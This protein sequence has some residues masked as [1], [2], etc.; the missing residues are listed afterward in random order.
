MIVFYTIIFPGILFTVF[1]GLII[2]W[3][4]RKLSALFQHRV[5]PPWYQNFLDV[6]KLFGKE[7][8]VPELSASVVYILA[9]I[10][11]F[12]VITALST[13]LGCAVFLGIRIAG[14]VILII[15]LL[16]LCSMATFLGAAAS[17]N[18]Y[19]GIGASRELKMLLADEL[20]LIMV[21][22]V[23]VVKSGFDFNLLRLIYGSPAITSISGVI[24]YIL[25]LVCIQA[26]LAI[27]PF[28][29]PEAETELAGGVEIE[30]SGVLLGLW[31]LSKGMKFLVVPLLLSVL[32]FGVPQ[33]ISIVR[34]LWIAAFY[35]ITFLIVV[36][37]KNINPRI[38]IEKMLGFFW[39][40]LTPMAFIALLIAL[41]GG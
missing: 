2:W 34:Y 39:K 40:K 14:D 19:A 26:K 36:V 29:L 6:F 11:S 7:S 37:V 38:T 15:Y 3:L 41:L 27:Q 5:G 25:G 13:V 33:E 18:V 30:Y 10:V 8:I 12:S 28:D 24:A 21:I 31:K 20:V 9:P 1:A 32:F 35:L 4:E 23:P 22:L 17:R 16:I